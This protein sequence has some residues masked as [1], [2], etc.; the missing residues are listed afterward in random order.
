M[1]DDTPTDRLESGDGPA[2]GWRWSG[3]CGLMDCLMKWLQDWLWIGSDG[4]FQV[5]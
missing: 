1:P 5:E 4:G 2:V 3:G